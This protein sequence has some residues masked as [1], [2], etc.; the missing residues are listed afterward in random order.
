MGSATDR[1]IRV[2]DL[3]RDDDERKRKVDEARDI[4]YTDCL[5]VN[6]KKVE[7]ILKPTSLVPTRV[8]QPSF[9][10]WLLVKLMLSLQNAFSDRLSPFGL[11]VY[12]IVS[13]DIL[14]EVEIGVWKSLF[15]HL[16]RLLEAIDKSKLNVL[17]A[18]YAALDPFPTD[19]QFRRRQA[20]VQDM[21]E[22]LLGSVRS[23]DSVAT[24]SVALD[25]MYLK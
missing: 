13:V 17:N 16:L 1:M 9:N 8:R 11:D 23:Q 19:T 5:S 14:H 25:T 7:E 2:Q 12:R 18:R 20:P 24:L 6:T 21:T 4:I 3:R 10:V 15:I 22:P